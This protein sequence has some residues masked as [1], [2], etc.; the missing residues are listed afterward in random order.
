MESCD[1]NGIEAQGEGFAF[2]DYAQHPTGTGP[3]KFVEYDK[4]NNTVTLGRNDDYWG[5]KAEDQ[6]ADLQDH[7]R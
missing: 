4:A 5:E 3:Y 7:P 6:D 2:P 1:A